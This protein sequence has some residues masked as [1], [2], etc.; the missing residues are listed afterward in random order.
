MFAKVDA[1]LIYYTGFETQATDRFYL[2][3]MDGARQFH[4]S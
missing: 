4:L 2:V 3:K 1:G